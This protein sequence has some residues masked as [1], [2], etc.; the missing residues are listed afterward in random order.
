MPKEVI[1]Q[2]VNLK[3]K[4]LANKTVKIIIILALIVGLNVFNKNSQAI[5]T[6]LS[7]ELNTN[8]NPIRE[9][10]GLNMQQTFREIGID[11]VVNILD[12]GT[13]V[14]SVL[15]KPPNYQMGII[16]FSNG[17]SAEI[18]HLI[19]LPPKRSMENCM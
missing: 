15:A 6:V 1:K 2:G 5:D 13:F 4:Q 3:K 14:G 12:W 8:E 17:F 7:L 18:S 11:L 16:G 9:Q 19:H 10:Y